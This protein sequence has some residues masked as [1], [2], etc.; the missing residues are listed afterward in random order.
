MTLDKEIGKRILLACPGYYWHGSTEKEISSQF[1]RKD[2][3]KSEIWELR[4]LK[5]TTYF[6]I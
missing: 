5:E 2:E 1:V 6:H 3:K 4:G